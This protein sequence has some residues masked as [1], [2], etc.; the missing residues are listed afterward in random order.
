MV[1]AGGAAVPTRLRAMEPVEVAGAVAVTNGAGVGPP[2]V[3]PATEAPGI[4]L[5]AAAEAAWWGPRALREVVVAVA[6]VAWMPLGTGAAG[7]NLRPRQWAAVEAAA[8]AVWAA[9][10]AGLP[11]IAPATGMRQDLVHPSFFINLGHY[12]P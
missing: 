1:V 3:A 9:A 12:A 4:P 11:C 7:G 5:G 2:V 10:P 6:L 8:A